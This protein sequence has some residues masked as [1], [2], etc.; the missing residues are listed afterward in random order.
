MNVYLKQVAAGATWVLPWQIFLKERA[1]VANELEVKWQ[2]STLPNN[3][4]VVHTSVPQSITDKVSRVLFELHTHAEG[5]AIL[6]RISLSK[7]EKADEQTYQV[8]RDFIQTFITT[9]RPLTNP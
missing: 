2:T 4:L 5:Q 1:D 8:T 9:I 6:A 7:F 3:G